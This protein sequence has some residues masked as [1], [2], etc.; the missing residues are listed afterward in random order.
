[1]SSWLSSI[2]EFHS[3]VAVVGSMEPSHNSKVNG[4]LLSTEVLLLES[5]PKLETERCIS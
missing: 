2:I 3:M 1:M 4:L 5:F